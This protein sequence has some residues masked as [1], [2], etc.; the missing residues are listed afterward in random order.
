MTDH[1]AFRL[2]KSW[3]PA[4]V[5]AFCIFYVSSFPTLKTSQVYWQEFVVKKTAHMIEYAIF[6]LLIFRGFYTSG[7]PRTRCFFYTVLF[8]VCFALTDE[9]HQSFVPT[10]EPRL[11][12]VGFDTIGAT[13]ASYILWTILPRVP[14]K[15]RILAEK[16]Q[17]L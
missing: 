7:V 8:C 15:L 4:V 10:R 14:K 12:D 17:L 13:A 3:L 5:W 2:I 1:P 6:S 9:F 11:R 16:L